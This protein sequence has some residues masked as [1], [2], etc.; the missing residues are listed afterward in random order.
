MVGAARDLPLNETASWDGAAAAA[1]VF[2]AAGWPDNPNP[3]KAKRAFLVYNNDE[4]ELK[5]AYK[6]PFADLLGGTLTAIKAGINNAASRLPQTSI[7]SDVQNSARTVIDA[8]QAKYTKADDSPIES[9]QAP[10]FPKRKAT[11]GSAVEIRD[12][13]TI[14]ADGNIAPQTIELREDQTD[15]ETIPGY[16]GYFCTWN[17]VD[18]FGTFFTKGAFKKSLIERAAVAPVLWQHDRDRPIGTHLEIK[19]TKE[20]VFARTKLIEGVTAADDALLLL[21]HG[22]HLGLSFGFQTIKDRAATEEDAIDF[23]VAPAWCAA[24][25][26]EE[27]RAITEV[28]FWESS[29]VTFAANEKAAPSKVRALTD[30]DLL[31]ALVLALRAGT[32]DEGQT[33]LI[34]QIVAAHAERAGA[35]IEVSDEPDHSTLEQ[36]RQ[37]I[38]L[39]LALQT[40]RGLL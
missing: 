40:Y 6:L 7:P 9:T 26:R 36:A 22:V 12:A 38:D 32:L 5:Q 39:T 25:P 27:I 2:D 16:D 35:G 14:V 29:P 24:A 3:A 1:R 8:Y 15:G 4:D 37:Q 21:R 28:A 17:T 34:S 30:L 11:A 23:S 31:R 18:A 33:V 13:L 20:G 19:E 10:T